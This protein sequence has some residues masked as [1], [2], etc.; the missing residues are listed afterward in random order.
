MFNPQAY[1]NSRADGIGVLEVLDAREP[2]E[3]GRA[4][5]SPCGGRT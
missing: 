2:E 3:P 4:A 1:A 5:S